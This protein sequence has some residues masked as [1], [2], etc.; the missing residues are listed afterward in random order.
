MLGSIHTY[1]NGYGYGMRMPTERNRV[2]EKFSIPKYRHLPD[3]SR[4][5]AGTKN[6]PQ[7]LKDEKGERRMNDSIKFLTSGEVG[8]H[9]SS[10]FVDPLTGTS[11]LSPLK[12]SRLNQTNTNRS[13][14]NKNIFLSNNSTPRDSIDSSRQS[15]SRSSAM[16][17]SRSSSDNRFNIDSPIVSTRLNPFLDNSYKASSTDTNSNKKLMNA[18]LNSENSYRELSLAAS[19]TNLAARQAHTWGESLR[20]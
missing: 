12:S 19:S 5:I 13:A 11:S 2:A 14:R 20:K 6:K 18:I 3:T 8:L 9:T 7:I 4:F 16:T 15:T 1:T 17:T 10:S